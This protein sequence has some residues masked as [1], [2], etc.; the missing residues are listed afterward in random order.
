MCK[1]CDCKSANYSIR[2]T[3]SQ[4]FS[5]LLEGRKALIFYEAQNIEDV[6][7]GEDYIEFNYCP[8][9]GEKLE[10]K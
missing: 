10:D 9:C 2:D 1:Y 3:E 8:M 6:Q 5:L 7:E 4:G